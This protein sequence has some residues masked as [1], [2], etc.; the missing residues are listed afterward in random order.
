MTA[1]L[2]LKIENSPEPVGPPPQPVWKRPN[3]PL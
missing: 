2:R 1:V 3:S